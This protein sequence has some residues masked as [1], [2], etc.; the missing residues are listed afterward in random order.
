MKLQLMRGDHLADCARLY[1]AVFN[2]EPWNGKWTA[3]TAA[4]HIQE[5]L[6]DPNFRGIIALEAGQPI[7]FAYG[8]VCQ[9]EDEHRFYLKEM[10]VL[11]RQQRGGIGTRLLR[12]LM[13]KLKSE[14]V[15]QISPG[16]GRGTPAEGFYQRLGFK[17]DPKIIIMTKRSA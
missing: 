10:C 8:L 5:S 13:E 15:R 9:W 11:S 17:V 16:R 14:N 7:A 1:A 4:K 6:R 12:R 2:C 3:R